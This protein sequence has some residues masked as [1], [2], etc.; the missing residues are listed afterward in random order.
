MSSFCGSRCALLATQVVLAEVRKGLFP[1][2]GTHRRG[3]PLR[4]HL[5]SS[6]DRSESLVGPLEARINESC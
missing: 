3:S 5:L 2:V 6:A 4:A 1:L